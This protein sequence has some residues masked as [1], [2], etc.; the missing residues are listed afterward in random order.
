M[1]SRSEAL[2][3]SA[4]VR[5]PG[6]T[7]GLRAAPVPFPSGALRADPGLLADVRRYGSF[8]AVCLNCGTCS[9]A[10]DLTG[11]AVTFPRKPIHAVLIGLTG[12][13]RAGLE[14]WL[15]HDCGDC[16]LACP[17][18]A[19]PA[20]SMRT[21]RRYLTGQYDWTGLA[22]RVLR[23]RAWHFGALATVGALV[24]VL[25]LYY[26]LFWIDLDVGDLASP[27]ALGHMLPM[28]EQ[29]TW[30]VYALPAVVLVGHVWRMYR[31]TMRGVRASPKQFTIEARTLMVQ[32]ATQARM[33][34]CP[35]EARGSPMVGWWLYASNGDIVPRRWLKHWL[36]ALGTVMMVVLTAVFLR[37]FQTDVVYP[38]Y[39]PQRVLGYL[40]TGFILWGTT[41]VLVRRWRRR[42]AGIAR[43]RGPVTLP[44]FLWLTAVSGIALHV[45]RILGLELTAHYAYLAHLVICVPMVTV[46]VPFGEWAHMIDRPLA[47][48]F[49]AVR[50]RVRATPRAEAGLVPALT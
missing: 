23:S 32:V 37:W 2:N 25:F 42:D 49:A 44:L 48:Y 24:V 13:V 27:L 39:H 29:F 21:L 30:I 22:A 50:E 46:E 4:V 11:G 19:D 28:I 33:R 3:H 17:R 38:V 40:A 10:C 45:T 34:E 18:Q 31:L 12:E 15:C 8:D 5:S 14:P 47:L 41:D 26:H 6:S 20:A 36:M 43:E 7:A 1:A 16:S 35:T 9:V